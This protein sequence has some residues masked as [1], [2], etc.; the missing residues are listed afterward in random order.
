[1]VLNLVRLRHGQRPARLRGNS[2]RYQPVLVVTEHDVLEATMRKPS[3]LRIKE[4]ELESHVVRRGQFPAENVEVEFLAVVAATQSDEE[5]LKP[6]LPI[7][8]KALLLLIIRHL[9]GT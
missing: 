3:G 6:L 4:T 8:N 5:A 9:E 7:E 2:T 1:M